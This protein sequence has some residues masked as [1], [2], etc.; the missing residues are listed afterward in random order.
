V[1]GGGVPDLKGETL[2]EDVR[3]RYRGWGLR[4]L[5]CPSPAR[6]RAKS[7]FLARQLRGCPPSATRL[8]EQSHG[9]LPTA[10][11]D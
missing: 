5:P 8:I 7:T 9:S 3:N 6:E 10:K 11:E 1:S 4:P 2:G